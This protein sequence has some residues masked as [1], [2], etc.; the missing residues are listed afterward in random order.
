[1]TRFLNNY[2]TR[3]LNKTPNTRQIVAAL[4]IENGSGGKAAAAAVSDAIHVAADRAFGSPLGY[5][6]AFRRV[7]GSFYRE[8]L[9]PNSRVWLEASVFGKFFQDEA[10]NNQCESKSH[11][12]D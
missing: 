5:D 4:L 9:V 7:T 10:E 12:Q 11:G 1:M 2:L 3:D 6:D 8:K